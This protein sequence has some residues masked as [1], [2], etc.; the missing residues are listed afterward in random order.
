[1]CRFFET[2]Q[3]NKSLPLKIELHD[4]RMNRTRKELLGLSDRIGLAGYIAPPPELSAYPK[5]KCRVIYSAGIESVEYEP[6]IQKQACIL[7]IVHAKDFEYD[8]KYLDRAAIN[9][10]KE[11]APG[12]A[13]I[14]IV[15]DGLLT[16][17]SIHNIALYDG[18]RWLTP[19]TPLLC[20][21]Q[22]EYLLGCG[23]I[24]T[25]DIHFE[26]L[27]NYT[28]IRLFNAMNSWEECIELSTEYII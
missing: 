18:N 28:K 7:K 4:S 23:V 12:G 6:Y 25:K 22:R 27:G 17:T 11:D 15:R 14:L 1:M 20:G 16:D 10:L 21:I 9:R 2:I 3:V 8:Y 26:D 5:L 24:T 13:E 19:R